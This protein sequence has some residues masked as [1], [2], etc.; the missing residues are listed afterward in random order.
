MVVVGV[1]SMPF[2]AVVVWL[3]VLRRRLK[4]SGEAT[5]AELGKQRNTLERVRDNLAKLDDHLHSARKVQG[6]HLSSSSVLLVSLPGGLT[7]VACLVWR[8]A[9]VSGFFVNR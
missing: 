9:V 6:A 7:P 4:Q 5:A 8:G 1:Y 3:A 2:V